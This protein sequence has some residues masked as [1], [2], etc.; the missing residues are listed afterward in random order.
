MVVIKCPIIGCSYETT[1][2]S[3]A[4]ACV[5]LTAHTPQHTAKLPATGPKLDRPRIDTGI[6]QEEWNIFKLRWDVFV[7]GSGFDP[8]ASSSQLF[9]CAGEELGNSL[10]KADPSITSKPTADLMKAMETLAVVAVAT[11]VIRAELVQMKQDRGET[12]RTFAARVRGKAETCSYTTKCS[13]N[14]TVNFT[15]IIVRDVLI[16][17][18][19]D[20]D[21]RRDILGTDAIL[22]RPVNDVI[23]LV[24]SKEMARNALPTS[25]STVS[26]FKREKQHLPPKQHATTNRQQT[27]HCP[28]CSDTYNLYSEGRFGWNTRPHRICLKCYKEQRSQSTSQNSRNGPV[29][30]I[31]AQSQQTAQCP[32]CSNTYNLYSE[33]RFGWNTRPHRICL[34]CHKE[35]R[36][37]STN[38]N[39]RNGSV[40]HNAARNQLS[41]IRFE[42]LEMVQHPPSQVNLF[43]HIFTAGQWKTARFQDHPR[44]N[45]TVST[46]EADYLAF[47]R[48][49]I[50]AQSQ[51]TAQCPKC[52]NTYNLY[53]E[54]RFGWNTRPHRICLKCHK[55]QRSP[56]TNQNSRNG[57]VSH[58]AARN[59]LS[60]IRF[61]ALEMVQHPPS[62]VNLF[63]HIFTAGQWKTAR[64]Q[65]HPRVNLTVST[66]EADYLAFGRKNTSIKPFIVSA[67]VDSGAQSC[68]WSLKDFLSAGFAESDLLQVSVDLVAANRS[69]INVA[70]ALILRLQGRAKDSDKEY[71]CAS[72]VYV[73]KDANGFYLSCEAMVDLCI[74]PSNFPSIGAAPHVRVKP[75]T[76]R[77]LLRDRTLN[78]GCSH[79]SLTTDAPCSCP[80]RSV[81]PDRPKALPF[82]C[83][84]ENNVKMKDWLLK[85]FGSSTFNT[86]PHRPLPCMSGPPVEMH[87]KD[88]VTPK[89]VHKAAPVPVHWQE[90]VQAD[91]QRDEKL[92][93]IEKVPYG[94]PVTWCHRM[95]V[96]RKHDGS[97]RRTVDLSPLNKHCER[98]TFCSESPFH[99]ARKVPQATWKTVTDAWNGYHSVPLRVS[100][101]HL[102]TFITPFGRWRYTRAP[103]GF[104]S[105]GD[106]YNRRFD[107]IL[108]DFERKE[109]C[110]DDTIHYDTDLREHWWRTIDFLILTGRSGIV[111]NPDK[112]SFAQRTVDFAGFCISD[113][114]IEPLPKYLDAIRDFPRPTSIT[115][116]RSWFGLVN[117]VA[118]YAQ[119][120]DIMAPFKPFLS[121][122]HK[123]EWTS[124]LDNAFQLSK[125][126]IIDA[127]RLGVEIF[128]PK[129]Q[130]CLRPDWSRQG[131]G[132]FLLQKHCSCT[133]GLPDCCPDGWK[134]TLAGS[135]FLT[136]T[137]Q[138]YAP[139]EGEALAVAW[140]LEQTRYFTQGCRKLL[141][142]TD[143]KPLVK[144]LGDRTLD[145][146]SNTR[147]FRIKQRTLPWSFDIV[148]LPGKTNFAADATSRNPSPSTTAAVHSGL[149]QVE[150]ALVSSLHAE[151]RESI[152][153]SWETIA[154][155]TAADPTMH[156]LLE[157]VSN[158]FPDECRTEDSG[159]ASF[160]I[161]RDSLY[162]SDGVLLYNDRVVI[163]PAL[164]SKVLEILHAAH[165]GISAMESRARAIVFWPGLTDDIRT[166]RNSCSACNRA[167]PSQAATPSRPTPVPST[168]FESIYADFFM[169]AGNHYLVAGDRLSGWVEIFKA[170]SGT[171][172]S[173]A[174]GLILVLRDMFATFGVPEDMSSDGGPE[175]TAA[176]TL[177]FL[178]NWGI[179]HRI[180][181][182][183]YAQSNGRAEVAVKKAKRILMDNINPNGSLNN[184]NFLR[185]VYDTH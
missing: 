184:D 59:Q 56:S 85:E 132:Y 154:S 25:L 26:S 76:D 21:I 136:P 176:L 177:K 178:E 174:N 116:I 49:N 70:G 83:I 133:N 129:K 18:I 153:L 30:N 4:I 146:I 29:S 60:T 101:R 156:K 36:S 161:Y 102:T 72:M 113:S 165:Q 171:A 169:Y 112:F 17:G 139:I 57:S 55:E 20:L 6:T 35:Q 71:T 152:A 158:G 19:S 28:K 185:A 34:K 160:W 80:P 42:A 87:I 179:K 52:S 149:D 93:V 168:P 67:M 130:T 37:P 1:D 143:H 99:L 183:S 134:I 16:A 120:R 15:D 79:A 77:S 127:I 90:Q 125:S 24:E 39:S 33:G 110:V 9:Q 41:T 150:A 32:K 98:E 131:I 64:F 118:N 12:F 61:E 148:H 142:V 7:D 141:V 69:P 170:P 45:L 100:D 47:G 51:Q 105:S 157:V 84:P 48:K 38:Q 53:S 73:S 91:L 8:T 123:F 2:C 147:I 66:N 155:E 5:L 94:E 74:V 182:V 40:S 137:E 3:E 144:I 78:S 43:H 92:G 164:R 96:T 111:L 140:S 122:K 162:V 11:G 145:E 151:T 159:I 22:Q 128:D 126:A 114:S 103:Q 117:Q 63:H 82:T 97:P 14:S 109:R 104:L 181:S 44:V 31:A 135:R 54:G 163:P 166:Q 138:R 172:Q 88:N 81:V 46:N 50:A 167:A 86:C 89:A 13:C 115:D 68:L 175:F 106:G 58:N 27:T 121:P 124:E 65:D 107:A 62:Q 108:T 23:S 173:G 119:L 95:V 180:S 10:L 75:S